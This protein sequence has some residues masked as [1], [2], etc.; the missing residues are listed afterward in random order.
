MAESIELDLRK[1][2]TKPGAKQ[3]FRRLAGLDYISDEDVEVMIAKNDGDAFRDGLL[4][5]RQPAFEVN[6]GALWHG[7]SGSFEIHHFDGF[8]FAKSEDDGGIAGPFESALDAAEW[9]AGI[10]DMDYSEEYGTAASVHITSRYGDKGQRLISKREA[11]KVMAILTSHEGAP[12]D[13]YWCEAEPGKLFKDPL[14]GEAGKL[15]A[16]LHAALRDGHLD[17]IYIARHGLEKL[18]KKDRADDYVLG[19]ASKHFTSTFDSC[20][21][22]VPLDEAGKLARFRAEW[23]RICLPRRVGKKTLAA[24]IRIDNPIGLIDDLFPADKADNK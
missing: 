9:R 3:R 10:Y 17:R 14:H 8:F 7:N 2:F 21:M 23:V 19:E 6:W 13:Y 1:V 11:K 18:T 22:K 5:G 16:E 20:L 15:L 4:N 24:V 12:L